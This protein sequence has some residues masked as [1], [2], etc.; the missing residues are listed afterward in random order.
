MNQY[1]IGIS[2]SE[3]ILHFCLAHKKKNVWRL[4]ESHSH[5]LNSNNELGQ[6]L[7]ILRQQIP[8]RHRRII[9]GL[10]YHH[11]LMKEINIDASLQ[12]H[13]IY[14]Y[15]Q[16]Q[17][18]T[19]FGKTAKHWFID[20]EFCPLMPASSTQ[21][22]IR[23]VA[24]AREDVLP[25][26]RAFNSSHL[27]LHVIDIDVLALSRLMPWFEF[28]NPE[29]AQGLVW[30]KTAELIFLVAQAGSLLYCKRSFYTTEQ[31]LA[32][33]LAPLIQFYNGLFPQNILDLIFLMNDNSDNLF[34]DGLAH[35][36]LKIAKI[37]SALADKKTDISA[38]EFCSLGLAIY[39]Y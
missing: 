29:S 26:S 3:N 13:E 16:Q 5:T 32:E 39:E 9:L 19:F 20:Y 11:V 34:T 35:P 23:I 31:T 36:L 37:N 27:G 10:P 1:Q 12:D 17:A 38:H 22:R 28:F 15:L 30:I 7:R 33:I 2:L 4:L 25:L 18:S 8:R 21:R 14:F 24:A 6:V